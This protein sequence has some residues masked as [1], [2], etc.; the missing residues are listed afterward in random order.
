MRRRTDLAR[1]PVGAAVVRAGVGRRWP[2]ALLGGPLPWADAGLLDPTLTR[3]SCGSAVSIRF[4]KATAGEEQELVDT[5]Q[6]AVRLLALVGIVVVASA[7]G[8]CAAAACGT[9]SQGGGARLRRRTDLARRPLWAA[10]ARAGVGRRW[11]HKLLGEP[12][13]WAGGV[14]LLA[15]TTWGAGV[16]LRTGRDFR[17]VDVARYDEDYAGA[18]LAA[19]R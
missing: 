10:V 17:L 5:T 8:T 6:R 7:C 16:T 18:V 2:H 12:A 1:R 15:A 3:R 9:R 13:P 19:A 4:I 11:P 14:H